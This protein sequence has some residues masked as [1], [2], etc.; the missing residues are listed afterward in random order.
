MYAR[1]IRHGGDCRLHSR[2][3]FLATARGDSPGVALDEKSL[4]SSGA[5]VCWPHLAAVFLFF[6]LCRLLFGGIKLPVAAALLFGMAPFGYEA[7]TWMIA[8]C[9]VI[10][11]GLFL[12][13]LLLLA[14][15]TEI[16]WPTPALFC[17]SAFF[18]LLTGLSNE[19]LFFSTIFSGCFVWIKTPKG[20]LRLASMVRGR[21]LLTWAPLAGCSMWLVLYYAFKGS[22]M[23]KQITAMHLPTLLGFWLKQ[24]SLPEIFVPWTSP[25]CRQLIFSGWS[26]ATFTAIIACGVLFL[27]G[28]GRLSKVKELNSG[29]N[30]IAPCTLAA[31]L[32]ISFGASLIYVVG[33]GFSTD[34]RKK[35]PNRC[36]AA[37]TRLL[38]VSGSVQTSSI[39]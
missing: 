6:H 25:I 23:Q 9:Y 29:V 26:W 8:Y 36:F 4:L 7:Q 10:A 32:A 11:V 2:I 1:V 33:G 19:C 5:G 21:G 28:L 35:I 31:I 27:A 17:L 14:H 37:A 3:W 22:D 16:K 30:R 15:Q 39:W 24:Y 20:S 38:G 18:A 12:A 13:N 34:S